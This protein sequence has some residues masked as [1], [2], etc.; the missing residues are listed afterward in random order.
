MFPD[1]YRKIKTTFNL[2]VSLFFLYLLNKTRIHPNLVTYFGIFWV[3]TGVFSFLL[4]NKF[5]NYFGDGYIFY[6]THSRLY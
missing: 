5:F 6:K 2:E 4:P 1:P 3:Y